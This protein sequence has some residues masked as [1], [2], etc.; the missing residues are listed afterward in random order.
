MPQDPVAPAEP[1]TDLLRSE[2]LKPIHRACLVLR[3]AHGM[4]LS[5]VAHRTRLSEMQVRGHLQDAR[6][7]LR[8]ELSQREAKKNG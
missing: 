7:L 4:T 6:Q 2:V 5:E 8:T 1:E 3:Y